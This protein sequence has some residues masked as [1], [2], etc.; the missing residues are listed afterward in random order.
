MFSILALI[1][2]FGYTAYYIGKTIGKKTPT[3]SI[4]KKIKK[5]FFKLRKKLRWWVI[6]KNMAKSLILS[7]SWEKV[8][9]QCIH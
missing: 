8:R 3:P 2:I 4:L 5:H 7:K 1:I 9:H 6:P